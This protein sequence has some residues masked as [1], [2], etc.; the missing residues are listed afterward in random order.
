MQI[1]F[2]RA[3]EYGKIV[4]QLSVQIVCSRTYRSAKGMRAYQ[5]C[6]E[7]CQVFFP[8]QSSVVGMARV[9]N[10]IQATASS[11]EEIIGKIDIRKLIVDIIAVI[12]TAIP[13]AYLPAAIDQGGIDNI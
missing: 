7:I 11:N 6:K 12:I 13:L 5:A 8:Q 4:C 9:V 1:A 2:N 3:W 10:L